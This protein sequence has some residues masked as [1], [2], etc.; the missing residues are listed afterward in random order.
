MLRVW[1]AAA[2]SVSGVLP[3]V[4]LHLLLLFNVVLRSSSVLPDCEMQ[5]VAKRGL[6]TLGGRVVSDSFLPGGT[7]LLLPLSRRQYFT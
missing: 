1:I 6:A 4:L 2:C 3:C 5:Q 7:N